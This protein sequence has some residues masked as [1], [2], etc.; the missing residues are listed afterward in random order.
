M[1]SRPPMGYPIFNTPTALAPAIAATGW[2]V[3]STAATHSLDQG[4]FGVDGTLRALDA[5][6]VAHAGTGALGR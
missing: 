1:S 2:K 5:A 6:G 3:G 4:Q